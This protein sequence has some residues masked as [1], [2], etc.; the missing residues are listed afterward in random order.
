MFLLLEDSENDALL[1]RRAFEKGNI[2]NPVTTL[3]TAEDGMA[4]LLGL[5][6]YADR[7]QFPLPDRY[8]LQVVQKLLQSIT[9]NIDPQSISLRS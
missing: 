3:K 8:F 1:I 6:A 5:G 7:E 9:L 2:L 4:Y